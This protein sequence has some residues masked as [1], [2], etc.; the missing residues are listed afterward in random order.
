MVRR[1]GGGKYENKK[2]YRP[3]ENR[4]GKKGD[5]F[6]DRPGADRD[7]TGKKYRGNGTVRGTGCVP[8]RTRKGKTWKDR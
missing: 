3:V 5:G 7:K 4:T 6:Q 8:P 1:Y 2:S